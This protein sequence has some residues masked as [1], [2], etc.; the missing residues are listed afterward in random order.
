MKR[1]RALLTAGAIFVLG[2]C[3]ADTN[4]NQLFTQDGSDEMLSALLDEG[5]ILYNQG[6]YS[7]AATVLADATEKYPYSED[8]GIL[9][10]YAEL[11]A[12]G[13]SLFDIIKVIT[14]QEDD[15]ADET[16]AKIAECA[17]LTEIIATNGE[18]GKLDC[19][20]GIEPGEDVFEGGDLDALRASNPVLSAVSKV[21]TNLCGFYP[22]PTSSNDLRQD[23]WS[24]HDCAS[25]GLKADPNGRGVL[26]WALAHLF[27]ATVL[28]IQTTYLETQATS[29]GTAADGASLSSALSVLG[30]VVNATSDTA[31]FIDEAIYN[32]DTVVTSLSDIL[33]GDSDLGALEE[34][35]VKLRE[36]VQTSF[37]G[38][39]ESGPE[40]QGSVV[41]KVDNAITGNVADIQAFTPEETAEFCQGY[42]DVGGDIASLGAKIGGGFSCN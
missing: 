18:R 39:S 2:S 10:S 16:N 5:R 34:A 4:F 22:E 21:V 14:Y 20:L 24:R 1:I 25:K 28:N 3:G 33:P 41:N 32:L 31:S 38:G 19:M 42:Q 9:S 11:G 36:G 13:L 35:Q 8:A 29:L 12:A 17:A 15:I 23:G 30:T 26:V 7:E 6:K 37:G 27:E 40:T